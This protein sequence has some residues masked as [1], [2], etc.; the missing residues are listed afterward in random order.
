MSHASPK[1]RCKLRTLRN[2]ESS[3][4]FPA[5]RNLP[6]L[7]RLL[8]QPRHRFQH[9]VVARNASHHTNQ[10]VSSWLYPHCPCDPTYLERAS[11][12]LAIVSARWLTLIWRCALMK[13]QLPRANDRRLLIGKID[14]VQACYVI[15][16]VASYHYRLL[17]LGN[18]CQFICSF[19]IRRSFPWQSLVL[20]VIVLDTPTVPDGAEIQKP[21]II[22]SSSTAPN[23]LSIESS[24]TSVGWTC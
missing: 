6:E 18:P 23:F 4:S 19:Q 9:Y 17:L 8:R 15:E 7:N 14:L 5:L 16:T 1:S 10:N 3:R 22:V 21:P 13:P 12:L 24:R 2:P 20:N 11:P